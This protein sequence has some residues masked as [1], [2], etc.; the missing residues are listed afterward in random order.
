MRGDQHCWIGPAGGM[1]KSQVV[2]IQSLVEGIRSTIYEDYNQILF[3]DDKDTVTSS[4]NLDSSS[5]QLA[6]YRCAPNSTNIGYKSHKDAFPN[7]FPQEG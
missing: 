1:S 2:K 5:T 6:V 4:Q 3:Q 7:S